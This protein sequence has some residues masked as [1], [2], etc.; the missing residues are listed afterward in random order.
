VR[1]G[2]DAIEAARRANGPSDGRHHLAHLQVVDPADVPRFREL[3]AVATIQPLWATHEPQMDELT[4]PFLGAERS[5]LQYPFGSL[6]RAG[7]RIAGGSDWT[8]STPNV[9][10]QV[11][12]AV[13][14]VAPASRGLE[15]FLPEQALDVIDAFA[16]FT[17]GSA[18]VNHLDRETGTIEV[19][20]AADLVVLDRDVLD[21]AAGP[22]GDAVVIGTWVEGDLVH[23]TTEL[24]AFE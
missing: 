18:W 20:K 10:M 9:P 2:L 6:H 22:I 7:A 12:T 3:D 19:G 5:T 21:R 16:A 23:S 24:E 15:P 13:N 14:R 1:H 4:V 11:E 17:S 8:V